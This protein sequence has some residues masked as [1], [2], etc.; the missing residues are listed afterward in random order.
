M[1][2][3]GSCLDIQ[4]DY[5]N[6]LIF[7]E[8]LYSNILS[9]LW[10]LQVVVFGKIADFLSSAGGRYFVAGGFRW[11]IRQV[12]VSGST[13]RLSLSSFFPNRMQPVHLQPI[14]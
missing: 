5:E 12:L 10:T 6:F 1:I 7:L 4:K 8:I 14:I 2:Q 3:T 9:I 13:G 11:K